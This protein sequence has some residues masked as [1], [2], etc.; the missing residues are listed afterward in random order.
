MSTFLENLP[1]INFAEKDTAL[2][3][4]QVISRFEEKLGRRLYH[5]DP[6]RQI[7]LTFVYFLSLQRNNIDF[8]GKQNLLKY[9]GEGFL[10]NIAALVGT[11]RLEP[12]AASTTLEFALSTL[13]PSATLIPRGTRATPGNN[14]YFSTTEDVEIPAG[15]YSVTAHAVCTEVG[16]MG[17]GY[18]PGQIS[19]LVD[20]F[21]F[22]YS[23]RNLDL[24]QGGADK[25]DLDSLRER[26][27]LRPES[28]ST[29][30]PYGAYIY[31]AKTAS[32]LIV[33]VAVKSPSPGV[34]DVIPLLSGGEIPSQTLLDEVYDTLSADNRRPL[35]DMVVVRAPEAVYYGLDITYY[36]SRS[37]AAAGLTIRHR[38]A[39]A[40][41]D[42]I[43]WQKSQLGRDIN[44]SR[45]VE[46]VKGAGV[47]RVDMENIAPAFTPLDYFQL[48]IADMENVKLTY[49]GLEDD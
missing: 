26:T 9:A 25:E 5:G 31:W 33:D 49:G 12:V 21:P 45:L 14:I 24:T 20:T 43:L 10:E 2:I 15:E 39:Q 27:R 30:G 17:N 7:L 41:D 23:V 3:E 36:I 32:Q 19:R 11:E 1:D 22:S 28:Y 38:V 4:A 40:V 8:A 35:T 16:T 6:W 42:F 47:K 34:V 18:L 48:G 46:M 44:P 29:A 37:N 13:L